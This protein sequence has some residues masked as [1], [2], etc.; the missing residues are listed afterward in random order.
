MVV[1]VEIAMVTLPRRMSRTTCQIPRGFREVS[2]CHMLARKPVHWRPQRA[3]MRNSYLSSM[4]EHGAKT[5]KGL[6]L[7]KFR[8]CLW[9]AVEEE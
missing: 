2:L 6:S 8:E 3:T 9:V 1:A 4:D 7:E 5:E